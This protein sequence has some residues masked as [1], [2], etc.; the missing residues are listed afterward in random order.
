MKEETVVLLQYSC[1]DRGQCSAAILFLLGTV[2]IRRSQMQAVHQ[3]QD[4]IKSNPNKRRRTEA[5][6]NL[7]RGILCYYTNNR[8]RT[9][10]HQVTTN[11]EEEP[12]VGE[13]KTQGGHGIRKKLWMLMDTDRNEPAGCVGGVHD[14]Q[15]T[16]EDMCVSLAGL[17]LARPGRGEAGSM[18]GGGNCASD[19]RCHR[20]H[21]GRRDPDRS[22]CTH[23]TAWKRRKGKRRK[24]RSREPA[25]S[26]FSSS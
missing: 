24:S 4:Q 2:P 14:A 10:T 20:S 3:Y 13:L 18:M 15:A 6:F 12:V 19:P 22:Q 17:Q 26:F 23:G 16:N 8:A 25:H 11:E 21:R 7:D 1:D 9:H 5:Y